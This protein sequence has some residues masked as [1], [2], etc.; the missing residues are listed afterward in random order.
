MLRVL[1]RPEEDPEYRAR[2]KRLERHKAAASAEFREAAAPML[3]EL[4]SAG[5]EPNSIGI[6]AQSS[7]CKNA[8][9]IL[10]KWLPKITNR[11]VKEFIVRTL[12]VPW[13]KGAAE[14]A[15]IAEFCIA[16]D[17]ENL[18]LKWAIAN[19]L[20]VLA[21]DRMFNDIVELVR[22]KR[23]GRA[24]EMLAMALGKMKNPKAVDM[25]I[26][27][28]DDDEVA[29]HAII[30]LRKLNAIEARPYILPFLK[31]PKTWIRREAKK[32][33]NKIDDID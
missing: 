7:A 23:H 12:S 27:L 14:A 15:L 10:V 25:L 6:L 22:D 9:P 31:H 13:A 32:A 3:G 11:R 30:A 2:L 16:S 26:G 1:K 29:G 17:S 8:V 5:Y 20:E 24:R 33:I 21:T 28:L 19:A 4:A 18:G